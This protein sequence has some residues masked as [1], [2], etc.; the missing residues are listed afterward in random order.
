MISLTFKKL[1]VSALF[2]V[3]FMGFGVVFSPTPVSAAPCEPS[4]FFGLPAWYKYLETEKVPDPLTGG[5]TCNVEM[6][7]IEGTW[8]IIAAVIEIMLR[9]AAMVAVGFIIYGG[10]TYILSQSQP[11]KVKQA[12]KTTINAVV[13]L[14]IAIIA[15]ALVSFIAGSFK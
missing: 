5:E 15:A 2:L 6:R 7:G 14:V 1:A 9:L 11:D 10:V 4:V 13:G 12:L 8:L 3:S